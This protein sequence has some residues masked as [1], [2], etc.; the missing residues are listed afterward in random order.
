MKSSKDDEVGDG[1]LVPDKN[2]DRAQDGVEIG[3]R[4]FK[5][6]LAREWTDG[7]GEPMIDF[8]LPLSIVAVQVEMWTR[9][10]KKPENI[11]SPQP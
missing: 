3:D 11:S 9:P 7:E 5:L 2:G 4:L 10:S 8:S 1:Q 6:V